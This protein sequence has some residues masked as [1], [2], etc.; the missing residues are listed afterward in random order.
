MV[1]K[2]GEEIW[3]DKY[4]RI[5]VQFHWDRRGQEDENSSC[6]VRVAQGWAGK[7]WGSMFLP[8]IGQEV[9]V[10]FLE[11]DPDRPLVTGRVYNGEQPAPYALPGQQTQ[12]THQD[13][14]LQR[15]AAASTSCASRTRRTRR[16]SS[17]TPR[18][19]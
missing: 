1:G 13:A 18:R 2:S 11:G 14:V 8:R 4:G 12:S 16:R 6:W 19:T 7:G 10:S 15:A 9:L 3:T 17:S 5:K